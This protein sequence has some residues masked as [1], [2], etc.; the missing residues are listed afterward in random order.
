MGPSVANCPAL[1]PALALPGQVPSWGSLYLLSEPLFPRLYSGVIPGPPR[2]AAVRA[3]GDS[4]S[5]RSQ[6]RARHIQ[7]LRAM[8][9]TKSLPFCRTRW[10]SL[11]APAAAFGFGLFCGERACRVPCARALSR[12][13]GVWVS[14]AGGSLQKAWQETGTREF[15]GTGLTEGQ[16][17]GRCWVGA[18][19]TSGAPF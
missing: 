14:G 19:G 8:C 7:G 9:R 18:L 6:H 4:R 1:T 13:V 15:A 5:L 10:T 3:L 11:P 12:R 16:V 2:G 17:G